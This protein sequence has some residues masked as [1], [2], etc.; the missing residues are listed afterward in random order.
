M[1]Q[2]YRAAVFLNNTGVSLIQKGCI[3]QGIQALSDSVHVMDIAVQKLQEEQQRLPPFLL[4]LVH[5]EQGAARLQQE[6][7][8]QHDASTAQI[9]NAVRNA[10]HGLA[11][12]VVDS[13]PLMV[14]PNGYVVTSQPTVVHV[15]GDDESPRQVLERLEQHP[16]VP[17]LL[18]LEAA[19][20]ND[21][22]DDDDA[23]P[24]EASTPETYFAPPNPQV[25]EHFTQLS[26]LFTL[27]AG[28]MLYNFSLASACVE[29]RQSLLVLLQ[30]QNQQTQRPS[31][32]F[33]MNLSY[34]VLS[35][36][37]ALA[38]LTSNPA[39]VAAAQE[40][41]S[42]TTPIDLER[43]M[44]LALLLLSQLSLQAPQPYRQHYEILAAHTRERYPTAARTNTSEGQGDSS[45]TAQAA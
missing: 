39:A 36:A 32:Q 29:Q 40:Q 33:L 45:N 18:R 26:H 24:S 43:T 9:S 15:A 35:N 13:I 23:V 17:I 21:D 14:L 19:E 6:H 42:Q 16:S 11:S 3:Q 44:G 34:Q 2:D 7:E 12:P 1:R 30:W 25:Q 38:L 31:S 22:G 28:Q 41:T 20:M 5:G 27:R 8:R 4:Q 37:C 10:E